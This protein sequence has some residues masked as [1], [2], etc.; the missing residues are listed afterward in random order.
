MAVTEE[1]ARQF[2]SAQAALLKLDASLPGI[3]S[4]GDRNTPMGPVYEFVQRVDGIPVYGGVLTVHFNRDGRVVGFTNG[5]VPGALLA[6]GIPSVKREQAI[7]SARGAVPAGPPDDGDP[8]DV[9]APTARL[10]IYAQSGTPTL[11]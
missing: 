11:A 9:P 4:A 3:V 10:V 8:T 2:L 5:S 6:S 7:E 1:S